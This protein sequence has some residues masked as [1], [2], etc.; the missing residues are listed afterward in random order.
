MDSVDQVSLFATPVLIYS[1][2][3]ATELNHALRDQLLAEYAQSPGIQ[4]SNVGGWH[5]IPN[6]SQRPDPC[7]RALMEL[8]VHY[9][10]RATEALTQS[11]NLTIARHYQ[12]SVQA[13]AMVMRTHDYTVLHDHSEAHWSTVYYVDEGDADLDQFPD[14]GILAFVDPRGSI[15]SI[16][17][18]DFFPSTFKLRP[19]TSSLVVFPGWLQHYVHAYRGERPRICVSANV[20]MTAESR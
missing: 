2:D 19:R 9:V 15:S 1:L 7:F 3:S 18:Q 12:F 8:I 5:S 11:R 17:G 16:A 6:L 20:R 4:R 10:Y 13:W 14:S